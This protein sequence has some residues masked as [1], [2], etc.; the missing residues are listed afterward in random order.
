MGLAKLVVVGA[1]A[2]ADRAEAARSAELLAAELLP[3]F[4][5]AH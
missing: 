5:S 2:G 4:A 3:A 1:T